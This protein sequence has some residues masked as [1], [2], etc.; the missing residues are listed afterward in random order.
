MNLL[1]VKIDQLRKLSTQRLLYVLRTVT[2]RIS[3]IDNYY[4]PRCCEICHEY[5]GNNWEEDVAQHS[6][7]YVERH[8]EIKAILA[9]REHIERKPK[10]KQ[11]KKEKRR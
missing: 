10:K 2:A 7:L 6:R 8:T 4:G 11:F 5:L 1:D 9:T 3:F